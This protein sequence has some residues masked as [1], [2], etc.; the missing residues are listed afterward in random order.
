RQIVERE[1][2]PLDALLPLP[3]DRAVVPSAAQGGAA[4]GLLLDPDQH[5]GSSP[6]TPTTAPGSSGRAL[7]DRRGGRGRL[8]RR[9]PAARRGGGAAASR[10]AASR[11]SAA[12]AASRPAGG[13]PPSP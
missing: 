11:T 7:G 1:E 12:P 6:R 10:R 9:G 8:R 4:V 13:A 5:R 3:G 2:P